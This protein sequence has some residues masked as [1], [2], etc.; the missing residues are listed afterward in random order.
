MKE[1]TLEDFGIKKVDKRI[2]I[3]VVK[4]EGKTD[5]DIQFDGFEDAYDMVGVLVDALAA[6]AVQKGLISIM[7]MQTVETALTLAEH[8]HR[9][10]E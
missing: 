6:T 2:T 10:G 9:K 4:D 3:S 7:V 1:K 5:Y 8:R